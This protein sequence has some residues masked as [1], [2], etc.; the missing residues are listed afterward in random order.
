[1]KKRMIKAFAW[2]LA[3]L[4]PD[5]ITKALVLEHIQPWSNKVIIPGFLNMVRVMNRGAA[6]GFLNSKDTQWQIYAFI[7]ITLIALGFMIYLLWKGEQTDFFFVTGLGMI[8]GGAVGNLVDRV[9][10][11]QVVDFIDVHVGTLHWPAF[12]VADSGITLGA[13]SILISLYLQR[14]RMPKDG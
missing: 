3:I 1:M 14:R 2:T 6:F 11:G 13:L 4:I 7:A 5:L 8:M 9:R 12:N 10:L